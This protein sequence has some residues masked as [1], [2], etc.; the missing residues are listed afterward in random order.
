MD[1]ATFAG[2]ALAFGA[3]LGTIF[4]EGS[5]PLSVMLP[6]PMLL[7]FGGTLGAGLASG[8][9]KDAIRAFSTLGRWFTFKQPDL[10]STVQVVVGLADRA[11][12]EGL[13]S[14]EDAARTVDDQFL[15]DGLQAAIDGTDPDDLR[16]MLEDRI[17]SKRRQDKTTAKYF[18]AMGGY[19]PT[20]GIIGTVVSLV[21]VLENLTE[22]A[23][24][25][26][27]I[28]SA[29]V[30]TLWGL[31]SANLMWLPI[32]A[33]ITRCSELECAG[34]ELAVEGLLAIQSGANPRLVGQRLRSLMPPDAQ[35]P[36]AKKDAK[37]VAA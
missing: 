13:L 32:G 12:R 31:L 14:L 23:E 26:A 20:I 28:A 4:I 3:V 16:D 18:T 8:T 1:P 21:H 11:R 9:L 29:F 17:A 7:V 30:A 25:G 24:L 2:M 22:P 6:A 35:A 33:R 36:D 10:D 19:A 15:R 5:S 27:M 37:K 34:M